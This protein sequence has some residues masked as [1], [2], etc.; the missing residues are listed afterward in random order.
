MPRAHVRDAKKAGNSNGKCSSHRMREVQNIVANKYF[1]FEKN[2]IQF[3][4]IN[5][6]SSDRSLENYKENLTEKTE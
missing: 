3:N 5:H 4:Y 1:L 2:V 6:A